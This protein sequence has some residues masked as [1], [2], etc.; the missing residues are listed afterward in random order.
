MLFRS[1]LYNFLVLTNNKELSY[2]AFRYIAKLPKVRWCEF[3]SIAHPFPHVE[4]AYPQTSFPGAVE[5]SRQL[6]HIAAQLP[7]AVQ[8]C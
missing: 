7:F 3:E 2:P 1:A 5:V 8:S 6:C 4:V